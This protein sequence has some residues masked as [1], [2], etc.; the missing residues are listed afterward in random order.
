[1]SSAGNVKQYT[2]CVVSCLHPSIDSQ[3]HLC[4]F[5]TEVGGDYDNAALNA[6]Y[7]GRFY[8][9]V[10]GDDAVGATPSP[11]VLPLMQAA[12]KWHELGFYSSFYSPDAPETVWTVNQ[13]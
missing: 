11:Q 6:R 13:C 8:P 12:E 5:F 4:R 1:M 3:S 10:V 7:G 9:A 2:C